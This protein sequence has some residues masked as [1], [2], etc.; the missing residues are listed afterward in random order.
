LEAIAKPFWVEA[1]VTAIKHYEKSGFFRWHD[2]GDVQDI[3]HL[4]KICEIAKRLPR[5][6]FWLPTKENPIVSAFVRAGNVFPKNLVVRLS[7]YIL[8]AKPAI[9]YLHR[10][11]VVGSAVSK[12]NFTCP[13]SKQGNECKDCRL[14]WNKK[15]LIVTYHYH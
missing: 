9:G 8:E 10:L 1:M 12:E 13:A 3:E 2:S 6:S 7:A 15:T 14:C 4:A 11:G 5:I